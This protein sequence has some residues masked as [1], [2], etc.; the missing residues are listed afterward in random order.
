MDAIRKEFEGKDFVV[1]AANLAEFGP[2]R[3]RI[4]TKDNA[5]AYAKEKGYGFTFTYANDDLGKAWKVPG[6][7]TLFI[8]GKD[9]IVKEVMVGYNDQRMKQLVAELT[10]K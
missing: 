3:E 2:N 10:A 9:G 5:V 7:P 6:Y 4:Q 1:V 8:V